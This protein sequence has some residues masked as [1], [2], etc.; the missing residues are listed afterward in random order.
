MTR[1]YRRSPFSADHSRQWSEV[2]EY[3]SAGGAARAFDVQVRAGKYLDV[4]ALKGLDLAE[5]R[6]YSAFLAETARR[7][8]GSGGLHQMKSCPL[9]G[10]SQQTAAEALRVFDIPYL[11]CGSCGH[12]SVGAQAAPEVMNQVFAESE[13]HSSTYVDRDALEVRMTQIIKPKL[14]WCEV[15]FRRLTGRA[16]GSALDVGAGG[17]H[18]LAGASRRG[19][20][21]EG[22]EKS[23][24]SCA[25]AREAFN[26]DLSQDDFLATTVRPVD[27]VTFWGLLEYVAQPRDFIAAARRALTPEGMLIVEVPRVD[28]LGTLVQAM[29]G[30]VV[31]RHMDPTSHVNGFSD[32]SLCTALVEGGFAPV[33]AWYF[34]MDAYETCVQ[35]ALRLGNAGLFPALAEFIPAIQEAAD[36]GRQC[37][38]IIIA[39][40]PLNQK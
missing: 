16:P 40:V 19:I 28:A 5:T 33:A 37:D 12:V 22:F 17:G 23:K 21:V 39:A 14:D 34:G 13:A 2:W 4:L 31:A 20:K 27:L 29:E 24:A 25:F 7:L 36:R 32:E 3:R 26:L 6:E 11:R 38:D 9:C 18:F 30:A 1:W 35:M 15:E 8:Y 10:A